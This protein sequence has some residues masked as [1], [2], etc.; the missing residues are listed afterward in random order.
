MKN[1]H[2]SGVKIEKGIPIPQSTRGSVLAEALRKLKPQ[3]SFLWP[4]S[5]R[6]GLSQSAKYIG[7]KII[8]RTV[9]EEHVRVWRVK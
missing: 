7:I 2:S 8:T 1:G 6:S 4:I 9:D 5:K 3:E